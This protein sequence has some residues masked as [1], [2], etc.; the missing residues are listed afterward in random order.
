MSEERVPMT[1]KEYICLPRQS[2][3]V[4]ARKKIEVGDRFRIFDRHEEFLLKL[5]AGEISEAPFLEVTALPD[6]KTTDFTA[7]IAVI[8]EHLEK[9]NV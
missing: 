6:S 4:L 2:E 9:S 5:G 7:K 8:Q 3:F 1:L